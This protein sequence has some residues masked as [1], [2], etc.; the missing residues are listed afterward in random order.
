MSSISKIVN[1]IAVIKQLPVFSNLKWYEQNTIASKCIFVEYKK[2]E[3]IC[4][5]NTPADA[6]YCVVSGRVQ[7]YAAALNGEKG[8]VDFIHR[9]MYFGIISLL[10][11]E[12][13]SL[14][15][16]AINDSV[17][18]KIPKD[19][20]FKILEI[21][22]K[23][24]IEFS[25]SLSR[26]LR[27]KQAVQK[28]IFESHIISI[29]SPVKY[30]GSSTYAFNLA[31]HLEKETNKK[32]ILVNINS[33]LEKMASTGTATA[34]ASPKWKQTSVD[35]NDIID[36]HQKI[37]D[38]ISK[39]ELK[40]H[41][42]N[43]GLDPSDSWLVNQISHFV[44]LLA[45]DYHYVIVDLP[46][47]MDDVVFR[48]LS[49]SDIV[50]IIIRD[51]NEDLNLARQ[52]IDRLKDIQ[53]EK[54]N[55]EKVQV[56]ISGLEPKCYLSYEEVSR[57]IHY[58][59]FR[60]LPHIFHHELKVAVVSEDIMAIIPDAT[61][62]Y[63]K[64]L[65]RIARQIGGVLVGL[66]LGGGAALG[67]AHVGVIRVLERENIPVDIV[68]GS[69]I[70]ALIGAL[71]VTG[72]NCDELERVAREFE[73][74]AAT[75][76]LLDPT[77]PIAGLI[78]GDRIVQWLKKKLAEKT[79]YSTTIPLKIV[80]YDLLKR[81]ELILD[82]GLLVDA[83][84]QSIA[85][86][87]VLHPVS[88]GNRLIIDGGVVNPLPTNVIAGLGIKKIIAS[89]VLQSPHDVVKG[90]EITERKL[91]EEERVPFMKDPLRYIKFRLGRM[92]LKTFYPNIPDIIVRSLQAV[93][94]VISEQS[95]QQADVLIHPDLAGIQWFELYQVGELIKRG[96]EAA[97]RQ[98]PEMK[99]LIAE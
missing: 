3:I 18:V 74:K 83:V 40:V 46:N 36:N 32:V 31:Y 70:G 86:P 47:H 39:G 60:V 23:L 64:A 14:T 82:Q 77:F 76:N 63:S 90:Y 9:G 57:A 79:F 68:V 38:S 21:V 10:T 49:Q 59:V 25:Q 29:Y 35:L 66:V 51:Q 72:R 71:W 89:N 73:S 87:G 52:V 41:L 69:S 43:V 20:F 2:G 98:L 94:Y 1:R 54:F 33:T 67:V 78:K 84:R 37:T 7:A 55:K 85:I 53:R 34:E 58:D 97:M 75:S 16:E 27:G 88:K 4:K 61:S 15:F 22:P 26:R 56:M 5:E 28:S 45:N 50:H 91:K 30:S 81:E 42:L 11:G 48:T 19:D 96:E 99:K 92:L 65:R 93:E 17:L 44:S 13:H 6:F 12:N 95:A 8:D 24:G 80:A 62:E